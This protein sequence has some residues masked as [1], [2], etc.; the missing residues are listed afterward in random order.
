MA[1]GRLNHCKAC[2]NAYVKAWQ[3]ANPETRKKIARES[4]ANNRDPARAAVAW[5]KWYRGTA[6]TGTGYTKIRCRNALRDKAT[7]QATPPWARHP[8]IEKAYALAGKLTR[9]TGVQWDVD[10]IVPLQSKVVCGLHA[11][12]NLQ[13]MPHAD[14]LAKKN[15]YWPNMPQSELPCSF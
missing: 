4:A 14:N 8:L 15:F 11:H 9:G 1:D 6:R 12:T 3:V 5:Q 13:V 2:R 10:H 7:R